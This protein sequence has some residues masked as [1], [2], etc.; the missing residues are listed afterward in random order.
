MNDRGWEELVDLIDQ[1]YEIDDHQKLDEVMPD[2]PDLHRQIE[3]ITFSK[4]G[5]DYKIERIISPRILDKKT[6]Y[7]K[8]GASERDQYVYDPE[9]TS[10]R[11][12]F[13]RQVAGE[14]QEIKPEALFGTVAGQS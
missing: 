7:H 8:T 12:V 5:D 2:N 4:G 1:K 10:N 11:V 13:W 3:I 6:F 9:E 14:W